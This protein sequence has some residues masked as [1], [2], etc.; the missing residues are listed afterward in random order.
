[1]SSWG[2]SKGSCLISFSFD[3]SNNVGSLFDYFFHLHFH[4]HLTSSF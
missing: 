1:L 2:N 3:S 4:Q